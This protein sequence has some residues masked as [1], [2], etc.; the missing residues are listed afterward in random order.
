MILK[1]WCTV[2]HLHIKVFMRSKALIIVRFTKVVLVVRWWMLMLIAAKVI[3]MMIMRVVHFAGLLLEEISHF[4]YDIRI[5]SNMKIHQR[6]H[7]LLA[8]VGFAHLQRDEWI[9]IDQAK[10]QTIW[11][12][13]AKVWILRWIIIAQDI[14]GITAWMSR[15]GIGQSKADTICGQHFAL[16][17]LESLKSWQP[18]GGLS[19]GR[20][21]LQEEG[22]EVRLAGRGTLAVRPFDP[23]RG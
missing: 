21:T 19:K 10:I 5:G 2:H 1:D 16:Y 23:V 13:G 15:G 8:I 11:S 6:F 7:H 12:Q 20:L 3:V 22:H 17:Q 18:Q 4:L 14:R 9:N